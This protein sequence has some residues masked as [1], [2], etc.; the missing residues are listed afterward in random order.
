MNGG[1]IRGVWAGSNPV[2]ASVMCP[3]P[4]SCP[5]GASGA[6]PASGV[7]AS[8]RASTSNEARRLIAAPLD[9]LRSAPH[10]RQDRGAVLRRHGV[11]A[12]VR[13]IVHVAG[14]H[15]TGFVLVS[16]FEDENELVADVPVGR[17]GGARLE[18]REDRAPLLCPGLVLPDPLLAHTRPR[19]DPRQ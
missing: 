8:T 12:A 3:A 16:P 5:V 10:D 15:G 11:H 1:P 18:L 14:G 19:L 9:R 7:T 6:A 2:G 4:V 13:S 17:Q